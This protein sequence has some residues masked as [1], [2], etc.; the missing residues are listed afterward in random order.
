MRAKWPEEAEERTEAEERME[1][2]ERRTLASGFR[3]EA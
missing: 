3:R 2:E 1:A